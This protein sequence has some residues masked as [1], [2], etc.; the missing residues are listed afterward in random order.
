MPVEVS[1]ECVNHKDIP[2]MLQELDGIDKLLLLDGFQNVLQLGAGSVVA[3]VDDGIF[4]GAEVIQAA[5]VGSKVLAG[6]DNLGFSTHIVSAKDSLLGIDADHIK[7]TAG[8]VFTKTTV[9]I[10]QFGSLGLARGWELKHILLA[11]VFNSNFFAVGAGVSVS[12]QALAM[13]KVGHLF[14]LQRNLF[15]R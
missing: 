3:R 10:G 2:E 9:S 6:T 5:S 8:D 4:D 1:Q 13:G 12:E 15:L 14:H 11:I 7:D